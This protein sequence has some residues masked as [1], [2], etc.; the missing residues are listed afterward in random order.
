MK[1][2]L[3]AQNIGD[4]DIDGLGDNDREDKRYIRPKCLEGCTLQVLRDPL[5]IS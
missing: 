4:G 1:R 2:Y 5:Q 3:A